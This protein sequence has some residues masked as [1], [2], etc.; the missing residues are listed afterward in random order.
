VDMKRLSIV[1]VISILIFTSCSKNSETLNSTEVE[2]ISSESLSEACVAE[3]S[4]M[5]TVIISSLT[6][7][8]L[9]SSLATES[10]PNFS[11]TDSLLIGA[12]FSVSGT[13]GM[14]NPQGTITIDFKTGIT[15]RH[16]IL[17]KGILKINYSGRRWAIGSSH[18]ISFLG[19]SRNNVAI[20]DSTSY[21]IT[22]MTDSLATRRNF[23]HLLKKC[24]LTFP[25]Q[26]TFSREA[27]FIARINFVSK[28]TTLYPIDAI[29]SA[30]GITRY[31]E[32]F[33]MNISDSL[34]YKPQCIGAK[35]Y[36]PNEG[37]K[38]ITVGSSNYTVVYG[39]T[40]TCSQ[41]VKVNVGDRSATITVNSD[42]N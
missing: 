34:I 38:L 10:I 30:E 4:E 13:G 5:S 15:D 40:Q 23:H 16:G 9:G 12:A 41:T 17:R 2:I 11:L 3:A 25:D 22:N 35:I 26:K 7:S 14:N 42:G 36:L 18:S 8:K 27:E 6:D 20:D 32:K 19:Y 31:G 1:I 29:N 28:T 24:T 37:T 21:T 39:S 33:I